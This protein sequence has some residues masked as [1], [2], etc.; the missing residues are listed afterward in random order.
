MTQGPKTLFV[1]V[2]YALAEMRHGRR[3]I[4]DWYFNA[5]EGLVLRSRRANA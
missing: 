3:W 2:R 1:V 5:R 4:G